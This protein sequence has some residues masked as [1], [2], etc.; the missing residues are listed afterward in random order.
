M[1]IIAPMPKS[2]P[3]NVPKKNEPIEKIYD[4]YNDFLNTYNEKDKN[5]K[6]LFNE[7]KII[8]SLKV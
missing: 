4:I 7:I 1:P 8:K 6:K 3:I 5:L 2:K